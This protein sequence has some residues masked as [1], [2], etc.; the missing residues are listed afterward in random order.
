MRKIEI[1]INETTTNNVN[2]LQLI[3]YH[4]LKGRRI[5]A[6]RRHDRAT[7]GLS[8]KALSVYVGCRDVPLSEWP[9]AV[10]ESVESWTASVHKREVEN[11]KNDH[12]GRDLFASFVTKEGE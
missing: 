9:S 7:G 4:E 11:A 12:V 6:E 5:L 2:T 3:G 10:R 8:L 1:V